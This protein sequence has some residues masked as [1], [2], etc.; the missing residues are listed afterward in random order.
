MTIDVIGAGLGRTGTLTLK[1]A[2]EALGY[3]RCHHMTEVF[4][5]PEQEPFWRRAADGNAVDW[6][7]VFAGY[8]ATVDWPGAHF[9]RQLAGHYPAAKVVLT[10]RDPER[11]YDSISTTIF[12]ALAAMVANTPPDA[13][14]RFSDI[15][16]TQQT[17]GGDL[18][19]DNV[20]AAYERHNAEV[21]RTIPPERLLVFE[22]VQGWDP[23]CAFLG[24][25]VPDAPFPRTNSRDE[26]WSKIPVERR[27]PPA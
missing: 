11:W 12:P 16:V 15:I 22:A 2:L 17:F 4:A 10:R 5:H 20:I 19:R 3:D 14:G 8:R 25:A 24:V 18:S 13:P 23:L 26:F 1:I 7:E 21:V 27:P 9:Y 6:A